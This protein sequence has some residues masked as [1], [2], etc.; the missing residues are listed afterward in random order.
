LG[1]L[2]SRRNAELCG[3]I[4]IFA[5]PTIMIRRTVTPKNTDLHLSIPENYI[6]KEVE[7]ILYTTDEVKD[8]KAGVK[9]VPS[10]RGS[11][12]LSDEQYKDFQQYISDTRSEWNRSI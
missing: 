5:Y 3:G 11:L 9:S 8:E 7:V 12:H 2:G 1:N 10:L 6:G 4:V